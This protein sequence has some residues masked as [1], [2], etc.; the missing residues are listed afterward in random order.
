MHIHTNLLSLIMAAAGGLAASNLVAQE[1]DAAKSKP[2]A[3][4]TK[5]VMAAPSETAARAKIM[6]SDEWKQAGAEYQKW[7]ST[8]P[9]YTAGQIK[10]INENLDAQIQTMPSGELQAFL[11]DWQAKLKVLNGKNF[12]EAQ[13]WLGAYMTNMADGYRRKYL[14]SLG[15]TDIANLSA[16][17]LETSITNIRADRRSISSN[18]EAFDQFRQQQLQSLQNKQTTLQQARQQSA[19]QLNSNYNSVFQGPYSPPFNNNFIPTFG[20]Y[21]PL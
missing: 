17:Q 8:Q 14:E 15:L 6:A 10:R 11:D 2:D 4:A 21:L 20:A 1:A 13:N 18:Q 12:Q 9:I 19:S 7:L 3:S 5:S 16:A